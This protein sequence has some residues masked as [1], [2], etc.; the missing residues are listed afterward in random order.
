MSVRTISAED[1]SYA[2]VEE[3]NRAW[4]QECYRRLYLILEEHPYLSS[5]LT[6]EAQGWLRTVAGEYFPVLPSGQPDFEL[7]PDSD[8]VL[9]TPEPTP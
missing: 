5:L 4:A 6:S 1:T 2:A 3:R 9:E 7:E 8:L